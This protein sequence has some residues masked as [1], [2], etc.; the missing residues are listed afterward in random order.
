[1]IVLDVSGL[2]MGVPSAED[3]DT[4]ATLERF[5]GQHPSV[6]EIWLL[7]RVWSSDPPRWLYRGVAYRNPRAA[8]TLPGAVGMSVLADLDVLSQS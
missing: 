4:R 6:S 8:T 5:G 3:H 2:G 1:M 7:T